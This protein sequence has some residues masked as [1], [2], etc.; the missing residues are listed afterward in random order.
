MDFEKRIEEIKEIVENQNKWREHETVNLIASENVT[1]PLVDA[2]YCSDFSH[3]YAEGEPYHRYYNGTK[4]IDELEEEA[5]ELAKKLFKAKQVTLQPISGT[6]ANYAAFR[7]FTRPGDTIISNST[8]GGG[9]ISHNKFGAA[10]MLGLSVSSFPLAEDGYHL[11]VEKTLSLIKRIARDRM[12]YLSL[13]VFGCSLFLFPQPVK[14][15]APEAEKYNVHIIYDAAHVLGLIAGGKFQDPLRE[16][17]ELITSSTHKTF[18]GPQGGM[19]LSNM[20][21]EEW[22]RKKGFVFPGVISNHH[23]HRIPAL[24]IALLEFM[25]FGKEYAEQVVKNAKALGESLAENGFKVEG[26]QF[27]YTE[28]HQLAVDVSEIGGG[29]KVA[30]LCEKNNIILNKNL[31]P[32]DK[33]SAA[34]LQNPSGIR[35]GVQEMTRY[36]MKEK[37]MEEIAKYIKLSVENKDVKQKVKEF[38][39]QFDKTKYTF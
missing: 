37:E 1:S 17:A 7:M 18:F 33:I 25:K 4:Y 39:K 16:G 22:K 11:D 35:I 12:N 14:E 8:Q 36:G 19:I 34:T 23:L 29:Q 32:K 3:R 26:E 31:L 6:V 27:G 15:I 13:L 5:N 30:D 38:R 28:S 10:G 2:A 20:E 9:H 24:A 21:N